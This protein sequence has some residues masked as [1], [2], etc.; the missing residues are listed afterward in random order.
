MTPIVKSSKS[1]ILFPNEKPH[2]GSCQINQFSHQP[3]QRNTSSE[4]TQYQLN[5]NRFLNEI[6]SAGCTGAPSRS[7]MCKGTSYQATTRNA[8]L[9][10]DNDRNPQGN[11]RKTNCRMN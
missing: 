5:R 3:L 2:Y 4:Q 10:N 11:N 6:P 9:K 1:F 8:T 7:N